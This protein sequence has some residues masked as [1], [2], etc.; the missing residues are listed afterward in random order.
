MSSDPISNLSQLEQLDRIEN[1]LKPSTWMCA[2]TNKALSKQDMKAVSVLR[3]SC[4][5]LTPQSSSQTQ[6]RQMRV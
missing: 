1:V 4:G 2:R 5:V 6:N 3:P